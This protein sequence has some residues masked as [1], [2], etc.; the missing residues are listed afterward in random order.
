MKFRSDVG[1]ISGVWVSRFSGGTIQKRGLC[2]STPENSPPPPTTLEIYPVGKKMGRKGK[3]E[4]RRARE[5][6]KEG[7][8]GKNFGNDGGRGEK[9]TF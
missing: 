8:K 3:K 7:R 4:K 2:K 6:E 1:G 5:E 9:R